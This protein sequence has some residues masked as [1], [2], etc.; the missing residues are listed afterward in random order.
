VL[1]H[2]VGG[3]VSGVRPGRTLTEDLVDLPRRSRATF[4]VAELEVPAGREIEKLQSQLATLQLKLAH[5]ESLVEQ[6]TKD[7][8][9]MHA[10][11]TRH[12][13]CLRSLSQALQPIAAR[14]QQQQQ[15]GVSDDSRVLEEARDLEQQVG[16]FREVLTD[17]ARRSQSIGMRRRPA[18]STTTTTSTGV[19]TSTAT[20][21]PML[22][23]IHARTSD[24]EFSD[25][26][27]EDA[28]LRESPV[29]SP[30]PWSSTGFSP[31]RQPGTRPEDGSPPPPGGG[32]G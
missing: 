30:L 2:H 12:A 26:I 15:R 19:A 28:L 13:D 9:T 3:H 18:S 6:K 29:A 16:Q 27:D 17:T 1:I 22:Q 7:V 20:M 11:G 10:Y 8:S 32:F 5:S 23:A 14:L 31:T 4:E 21:S 24:A 25:T